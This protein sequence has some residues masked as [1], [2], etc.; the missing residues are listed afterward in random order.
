MGFG[1]FLSKASKFA[2]SAG[3]KLSKVNNGFRQ[4]SSVAAQVLDHPITKAVAESHPKLGEA[5]GKAREFHSVVNDSHNRLQDIFEKGK[6]H[7]T[8]FKN[9]IAHHNPLERAHVREE[10]E[11]QGPVYG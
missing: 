10:S 7:M 6:K 5:Y 11:N 3:S 1:S 4:I 8:D 9:E 2:S